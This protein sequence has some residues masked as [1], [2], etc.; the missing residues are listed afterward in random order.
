MDEINEMNERRDATC[1]DEHGGPVDAVEAD[2]VLAD[3]VRV[4]GPEG[5]E[6][7]AGVHAVHAAHVVRERVEPHV[8]VPTINRDEVVVGVSSLGLSLSLF[9]VFCVCARGCALRLSMDAVDAVEG[10][11]RRRETH[12]TCFWSKPSGTGMPQW[13]E[14]REMD[15]SGTLSASSNMAT[16]WP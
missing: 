1:A 7:V 4:R 10:K 6:G 3:D 9:C 8:P 2:D 14:V 16:T 5:R 13:N 15:K 11:R 12:M